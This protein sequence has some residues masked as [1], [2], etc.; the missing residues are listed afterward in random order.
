M[1]SELKQKIIWEVI[2]VIATIMLFRGV[3]TLMDKIDFFMTEPFLYASIA[4]G[5]FFSA[6]ALYKI[7]CCKI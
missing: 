3:W 5:I 6:I 2:F 7:H 4:I 1:N